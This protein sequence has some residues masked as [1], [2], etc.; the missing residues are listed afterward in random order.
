MGHAGGE[1]R[2][3]VKAVGAIAALTAGT[4][5]VLPA[6]AM[7]CAVLWICPLNIGKAF[8]KTENDGGGWVSAQPGFCNP[9][10]C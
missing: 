10:D 8:N 4:K 1:G 2:S 5:I 9:C 6:E 7:G 3:L